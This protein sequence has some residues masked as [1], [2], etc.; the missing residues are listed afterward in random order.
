MSVRKS[1][2]SSD[3]IRRNL[4][5]CGA[6]AH[7][8][9]TQCILIFCWFPF[10]SDIWNLGDYC[11]EKESEYKA[12]GLHTLFGSPPAGRFTP[13]DTVLIRE[14]MFAEKNVLTECV[15]YKR[16][17]FDLATLPKLILHA[18]CGRHNIPLPTYDCTRSDRQFYSSVTVQD[19]QY[20][21]VFW[22]RNA[23]YA[24]QAAALVA[25]FRLG[26]YEED[27]LLSVGCLHKR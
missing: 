9:L 13:N 1:F 19:K 2:R 11:R 6:R 24:Q 15:H 21:S 18:Y 27:F 25:C 4:V 23:K 3:I 26:L 17:F 5:R 14:Q 22:H 8:Y 16:H 20:A 10:C 12:K 7:A